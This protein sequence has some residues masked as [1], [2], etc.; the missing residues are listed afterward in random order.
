MCWRISD[1]LT[2]LGYRVNSSR[3]Y[4]SSESLLSTCKLQMLY[5]YYTS[6]FEQAFTWR[7]GNTPLTQ[8]LPLCP[9]PTP[10]AEG[11]Q[12][13]S[14]NRV[15]QSQFWETFGFSVSSLK[16]LRSLL[17]RRT[18][19]GVW[20]E[21]KGGMGPIWWRHPWHFCPRPVFLLIFPKAKQSKAKQS[22]AKQ[23][24]AKQEEYFQNSLT[25]LCC[26]SCS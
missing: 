5:A 4:C 11:R 20:R 26:Y 19:R 6:Q 10:K 22:K 1:A 3:K 15:L 18:G 17:T 21:R 16:Q 13:C 12:S 14:E 7:A 23:S 2:P 24:K 9:V 8:A 25:L